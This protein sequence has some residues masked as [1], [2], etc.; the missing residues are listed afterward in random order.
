MS[1]TTAELKGTSNGDSS[2]ELAQLYS[3]VSGV[4]KEHGEELIEKLSLEK[5]MKILDLGC[6]TGYLS[7]V[8][9]DCVGPEGSVVAI[10]PNKGRL[11]IAKKRYS[12]PNLMFLEANDATLPEDQYDLVFSNYVLQWIKNKAAVLNKVYQNLKPGG[13][14]A[15]IVPECLPPIF[16]QMDNLMGLEV[17]NKMKQDHHCVSASEYNHIA[18][19]IGFK[20]TSS[21]VEIVQSNFANIDGLLKW[22]CGSTEGRFDPE[23]VDPT[24]LETFKR[25][26]GDGP[27]ELSCP[28]LTII[29]S[30]LTLKLIICTV[31]IVAS[32]PPRR[33]YSSY[34]QPVV[35]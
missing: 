21:E 23:K 32:Y 14:F 7:A 29:L 19:T 18:T 17:A 25:P 31:Y 28:R 27:S 13:R 35:N 34:K 24:I 1:Y 4:Q 33:L 9:A 16:E 26:F 11:E 2:V 22:H 30:K 6:G 12:R 20:V 10:D 8:L 15:F 3:E 5:N